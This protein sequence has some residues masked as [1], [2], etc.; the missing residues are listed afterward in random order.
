MVRSD[1]GEIKWQGKDLGGDLVL[2][3]RAKGYEIGDPLY[4]LGVVVD[5]QSLIHI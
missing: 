1:K 2:S 5:D 3:R 4:N